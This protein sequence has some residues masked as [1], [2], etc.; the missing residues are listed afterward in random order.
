LDAAI[1]LQTRRVDAARARRDVVV[2][3]L[4]QSIRE[5]AVRLAAADRQVRL[6][7]ST[8]LPQIEHAFELTRLAYAAGDGTFTEM[9]ETQR[10]LLSAQL[11]RV[12]ARASAARARARLAA[13]AGVL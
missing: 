4:R 8:V 3:G 7:D 2:A 6:I 1:E 10:M 11:Q 9:L 12:E 5:A 13:A